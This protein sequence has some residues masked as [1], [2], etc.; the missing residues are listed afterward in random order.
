MKKIL[1]IALALCM[2]LSLGVMASAE[3]AKELTLWTYPIGNW[4]NPEAVEALMANF[5]AASG[6]KVTVEYLD[7]TSGDDQ[8]NTAIEGNAAPD[9]IIEGPERLVMK[10]GVG[11]Y[12]VD[13]GEL[14][15]SE[16]A[17]GIYESIKNACQFDGTYYEY[18]LCMVAHNMAINYDV[19][20]AADALQYINL[21][22]HTWTTENFIKAVDAV[23]A[24]T[25]MPVAT[26]YCGGQGGD[27]GTRALVNN[28]YNGTYTN[29]EHTEY[30]AN[31]AENV[32]ALELLQSW[33]AITFDPAIVAGDEIQLFRQGVLN[34]AF[35]W[36]AAQQ[37]NTDNN[38]AGLTNDGNRIFMMNFPSEDG[39]AE[40]YGGIWGFGIFDNGDAAKIEAAKEFIKYFC[41]G[42]GTADAVRTSSQFPVRASVEGVFAGTETEEIMNE[43]SAN[44]LPN[45]GDYYNV[46]PGWAGQRTEWWNMLQRIGA[47]GD[48]LTETT[49]F[50]EAS[51]ALAAE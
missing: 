29:P 7:Y 17:Q 13:L 50:V 27:Q 2:V 23:Y 49:A 26:V 10:W 34:M 28:L 47:G 9:L 38:D 5:E 46:I 25:G 44:F 45:L 3:P 36:N 33:D 16:E 51:N 8:V 1:A 12:M 37:T 48:V 14:Y 4:S 42:E 24:Y 21:D 39:K 32:K 19:F 18:P 22:D 11:G 30:T 35:C 15:E 40:L 31:S 43:Y 6:I 41:D 20:E